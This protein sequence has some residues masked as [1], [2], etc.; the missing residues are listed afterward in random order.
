MQA[1]V[2]ESSDPLQL[3]TQVA[4]T[5]KETSVQLVDGEGTLAT[6][7]AALM[8]L[9]LSTFQAMMAAWC[10][11]DSMALL[12]PATDIVRTGALSTEES[13]FL[14]I[15]YT[16]R[17]HETDIDHAVRVRMAPAYV[18]YD[19]AAFERFQSFF[20]MSDEAAVDLSAL[21]AQATTRMQEMRVRPRSPFHYHCVKRGRRIVGCGI[22]DLR[23]SPSR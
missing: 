10:S 22:A 21:G 13:N 8:R 6:L 1:S 12:T 16:S 15:D 5:V 9:G 14:H 2:I 3:L 11:V 17:P 4:V 18:T 19:I 20:T 7:S 23:S